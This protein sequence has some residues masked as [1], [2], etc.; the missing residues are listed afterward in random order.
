MVSDSDSDRSDTAK[1]AIKALM[2]QGVETFTADALLK[3]K[4]ELNG[5]SRITKVEASNILRSSLGYLANQLQT[6]KD[7]VRSKLI[8][9]RDELLGERFLQKRLG[10]V[11]ESINDKEFQAEALGPPIYTHTVIEKALIRLTRALSDARKG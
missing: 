5:D 10:E 4:S 2:S 7:R 3:A 6:E 8:D 1:A 11:E 9:Q